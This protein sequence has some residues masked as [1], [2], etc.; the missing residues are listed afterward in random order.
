M[1]HALSAPSGT[2]RRFHGVVLLG[3]GT[4]RHPGMVQGRN[5]KLGQAGGWGLIGLLNRRLL[6]AFLDQPID[7]HADM[8]CLGCGVGQSDGAVESDAG[9]LVAAELHE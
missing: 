7:M 4:Y 3:S 1:S 5:A 8:C 9:L 2:S 6:A